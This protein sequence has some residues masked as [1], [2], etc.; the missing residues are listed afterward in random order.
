MSI[1][2]PG[3][4]KEGEEKLNNLL[5]CFT[6]SDYD[7][8]KLLLGH[9]HFESRHIDEL[10]DL[11]EVTP[12]PLHRNKKYCLRSSLLIKKSFRKKSPLI[13]CLSFR[14]VTE[15]TIQN[16]YV[17]CSLINMGF[18]ISESAKVCIINVTSLKSYSS[19]LYLPWLCTLYSP[20]YF[21]RKKFVGVPRGNPIARAA[22][23]AG[24]K[25]RWRH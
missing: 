12:R 16:Q 4:L 24:S 14:L 8:L 7:G 6:S 21:D 5:K 17:T 23:W 9:K 20:P 1:I 13:T 22:F 19:N 2:E 3:E 15:S 10:L 11:I 18:S 25:Y